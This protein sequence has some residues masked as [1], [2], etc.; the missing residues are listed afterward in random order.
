[1]SRAIRA[2]PR[3]PVR[4]NGTIAH[5]EH[6][7]SAEVTTLASGSGG[8]LGQRVVLVVG[9][10]ETVDAAEEIAKTDTLNLLDQHRA[11]GCLCI[12][13]ASADQVGRGLHAKPRDILAL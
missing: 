8:V 12:F 4:V 7:P 9:A 13:Q 6:T 10:W 11:M 3:C 1:M 2:R 5:S